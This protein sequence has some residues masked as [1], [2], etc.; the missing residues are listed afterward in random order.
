MDPLGI[1]H[2]ALPLLFVPFRAVA[3]DVL[4]TTVD[5]SERPY[6]Y[7]IFNVQ[8]GDSPDDSQTIFEE[9]MAIEL[10]PQEVQIRVQS[11]NGQDFQTTFIDHL[12]T[13]GVDTNTRLRGDAYGSIFLQLATE[14]MDRRIIA[15]TRSIRTES[16][17]LPEPAALRAQIAEQYG[18]P[19]R[20]EVNGPTMRLTYAW[21]TDGFIS[22]LDNVAEQT[23][24]HDPGDGN[25][26]AFRYR[27]CATTGGEV[28]YRFN[29]LRRQPKMP[30]CTALF[31]VT[32]QGGSPMSEV[33]FALYDYDLDRRHTAAVDAQIKAALSDNVEPSD[34]DL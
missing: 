6:P 3:E 27:P 33:H 28:G 16:D 19:S 1:K 29:E 32:Y 20:V 30:G 23:I 7:A 24:E 34:M 11:P 18:Q 15:I 2:L 4:E 17:N 22:D 10:V 21:G 25:I 5:P 13:A 14:A 8:P 31:I 9:R 12:L 26:K